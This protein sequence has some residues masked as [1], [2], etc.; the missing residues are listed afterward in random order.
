MPCPELGVTHCKTNTGTG[1]VLSVLLGTED[2]H[3]FIYTRMK[4]FVLAREKNI[5]DIVKSNGIRFSS[6]MVLN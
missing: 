6:E 5:F 4:N 2:R 1:L 3:A